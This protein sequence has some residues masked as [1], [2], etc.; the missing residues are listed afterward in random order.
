MP[1]LATISGARIWCAEMPAAFI[2]T[3]SLC[4]LRPV[5]A[6]S[7]PSRTEKGRKREISSGRRSDDIVPQLGIAIAGHGEDLAGLAE[8]VE[9]HQDQDQ[10]DQHREAA[11]EEQLDRVEARAAAT[12][13]SAG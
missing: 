2:A 12:G 11:R 4:W 1:R 8:Q 5:K 3:T 7:V 10:R 9:R 13:R 6:I